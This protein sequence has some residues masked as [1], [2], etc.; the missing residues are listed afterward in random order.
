MTVWQL[1]LAGG[2]VMVPIILCSIFSWAI[3]IERLFFYRAYKVDFKKT[4]ENIFNLLR[5]NQIQEALN[6][7]ESNPNYITNIIKVG[8]I[9]YNQPKDVIK[10]SI[11]N[12]YLY[13]IPPLEKNLNFL[14]ALAHISPLL[15][16]LGTVTGM[17]RSFYTIHIKAM[18]LSGGVNPSDLAGGIYEALITTAAGLMVAIPAYLAYNYFVYLVNNYSLRMEMVANDFLEFVSSNN[19]KTDRKR[20]KYDN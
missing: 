13:E 8:I 19:N 5:N 3:I 7:C 9:N 14:S 2:W 4:T 11:E 16:L 10:E 18:E 6:Y 20:V 12:M 15:G 17:I 1:I